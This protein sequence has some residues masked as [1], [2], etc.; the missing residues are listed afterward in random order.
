MK[1]IHTVEYKQ[2]LAWMREGRKEKGLTMREVAQVMKLP[3]SWVGKVEIGERRLDILEY[4]KFCKVLGLDPHE[5]LSLVERQMRAPSPKAG[6]RKSAAKK[7][8]KA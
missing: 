1:T 5:G 8:K 3:H 4:V 7:R 2:L 6:G